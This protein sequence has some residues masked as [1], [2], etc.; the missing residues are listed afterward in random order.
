MRVSNGECRHRDEQSN[1]D[2]M[3]DVRIPT[4]IGGVSPTQHARVAV[5]FKRLL[6]HRLPSRTVLPHATAAPVWVAIA[7]ERV[8]EPLGVTLAAT[9]EYF[10]LYLTRISLDASVTDITRDR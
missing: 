7:G 6:A 10:A 9:E 2:E 4:E 3:V 1:R 5:P 8:R